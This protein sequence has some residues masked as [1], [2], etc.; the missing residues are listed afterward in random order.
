[1]RI[2]SVYSLRPM[3][4]SCDIVKIIK[5]GI[6]MINPPMD[7]VSESDIWGCAIWHHELMGHKNISFIR[8]DPRFRN[9]HLIASS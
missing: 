8:I 9:H 7:T 5:T 4:V 2:Q 6:Y 3:K 1:M